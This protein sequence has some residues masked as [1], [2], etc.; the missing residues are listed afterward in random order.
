MPPLD[1]SRSAFAASYAE[2]RAIA[3]AEMAEIVARRSPLARRIVALALGI[4]AS[5]LARSL[6]ALDGD[7]A[8]GTMREAALR[9]LEHY[10]VDARL[11]RDGGAVR[12]RALRPADAPVPRAG[13][14]LVVSNHPGLFDALA[15][16]AAVGRDDMA[17]LAA[18]R[19]L[20][21][22]LPHLSRRLL[23]IDPGAAGAAAIRKALRHLRGGG[24]LLHF[25]AGRIEPDPC[26]APRGA[27]LLLPWKA[28]IDTLLAAGA[29]ACPGLRVCAAVVSGVISRRALRLAGALGRTEGLTD[30]LVPL[31]SLT[32]PGFADVDVEM[33]FGPVEDAGEAVTGERLRAAMEA[34]AE[35]ARGR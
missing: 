1:N 25:P 24:A 13:P 31:L 29:R 32:F 4:P 20:L 16:F 3:L 15:L 26:V 12:L 22:A 35:A 33:R 8:R 17:T 34:M 5:A 6:V 23:S 7:L 28:G 14:L 2:V 27:P 11:G 18:R 10:G 30:A 9:R 21:S 19:P